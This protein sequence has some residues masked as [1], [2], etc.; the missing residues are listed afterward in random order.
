MSVRKLSAT[1]SSSLSVRAARIKAT[2]FRGDANTI[3]LT[4]V[5]KHRD[6]ECA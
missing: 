6:E 4:I 2:D 3:K 5:E 1:G